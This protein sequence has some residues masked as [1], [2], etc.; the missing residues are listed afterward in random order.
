MKKFFYLLLSLLMI[1]QL[2]AQM[3]RMSSEKMKPALLVIDIQ[4]EYLQYMSE[5][6]KK[7]AMEMINGAIWLFRQ[8]QL[9]VIRVYHTDPQRGPK[10]DSEPFEYPSSVIV[11]KDDPKVIKNY[12][13]AFKKTDLEKILQEKGCNTV[14]LCGL[15]AVGCVLATYQSADDLDFNTF[16][17]KDALLSH[18]SNYTNFV[19]EICN[20]VNLTTLQFMLQYTQK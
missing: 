5:D 17:V 6:D 16:M 13:N 19:E 1:S 2:S 8:H 18:N 14:F 7:I 12:P 10:P 11:T 3:E 15:S 4:N 9:P 20:S